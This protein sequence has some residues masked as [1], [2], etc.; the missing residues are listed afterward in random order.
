MA[1]AD[2]LDSLAESAATL[3]QALAGAQAVTV[4]FEGELR[5][6]QE[7]MVFT[8]R[9][10]NALAGA[11]GRSLGRAFDGLVFD[12]LKLSDA[13][14][15][16]SQTIVESVY[17]IA[18]RPIQQAAGG[19]V[20]NGINALLSG[21]FPFEKGA[22]FAQGRVMPFAKGG[23]VSGPTLFPMRGGRGLMGEAGPEAIL[24]LSRSA[25]GRLGVQA[26]G[27]GRAVNLTIN[28]A[29]PDVRGFERSQG[30]IAAQLAR[31]VARGERNR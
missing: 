12:G 23:V 7:S 25:D 8:G 21:M 30:Q 13:L 9:E 15:S 19:A 24:P 29:T 31:A 16:V 1:D 17:A 18:M 10:V 20:A 5:R 27:G 6:M 26:Q 3:E 11:I 2:R 4:S 22:G 28:I 14:K